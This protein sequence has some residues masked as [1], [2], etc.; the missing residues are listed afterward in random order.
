MRPSKW[1]DCLPACALLLAG[2]GAQV[3][4][5]TATGPFEELLPQSFEERRVDD[6]TVLVLELAQAGQPAQVTVHLARDASCWRSP[7]N[8]H[9]CTV[10]DEAGVIA[11]ASVQ[12][13]GR[14]CE[15]EGWVERL[16]D[17][18]QLDLQVGIY[19]PCADGRLAAVVVR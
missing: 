18:W 17:T 7:G 11:E 3:T 8:Q 14:R 9:A 4:L 2:C 1:P 6:G 12:A 10:D 5:L 16:D 15:L 13:G 19:A